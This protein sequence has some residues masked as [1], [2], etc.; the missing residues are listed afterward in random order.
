MKSEK[1]KMRN[2]PKNFAENGKQNFSG[3]LMFIAGQK[4]TGCRG[5]DAGN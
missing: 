4:T 3:F 1:C 2:I 5:S